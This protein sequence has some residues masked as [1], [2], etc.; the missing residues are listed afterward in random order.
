M[1]LLDALTAYL[2]ALTAFRTQLTALH[3]SVAQGD[4]AGLLCAVERVYQRLGEVETRAEQLARVGDQP[5]P[6]ALEADLARLRR[7][8]AA[9]LA[10]LREQR[11]RTRDLLERLFSHNQV[12][13]VTLREQL[14]ADADYH[15]RAFDLEH[16]RLVDASA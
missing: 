8:L 14:R 15:Q 6:E 5:V 1:S 9:E 13:L 2:R 3:R 12:V 4:L 7:D 16:Q 11:E 10:L